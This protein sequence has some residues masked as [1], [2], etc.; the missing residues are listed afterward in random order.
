MKHL[1]IFA[2]LCAFTSCAPLQRS[3]TPTPRVDISFSNRAEKVVCAQLY[4]VTKSDSER[5]RLTQELI[6]T[7]SKSE[8]VDDRRGVASITGE[9]SSTLD[10]DFA[11]GMFETHLSDLDPGVRFVALTGCIG[12]TGYGNRF[13]LGAMAK[14]KL[15][16]ND[17]E[18]EIRVFARC[19]YR[20]ALQIQKEARANQRG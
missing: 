20:N 8:S 4:E 12:C 11:L 15:L 2:A 17:P 14:I 19:L 5:K 18:P 9:I 10:Y 13:I 7:L 1:F 16:R 6:E 3:S